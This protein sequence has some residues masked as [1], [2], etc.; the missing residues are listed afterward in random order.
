[1]KWDS[2]IKQYIGKKTK[3]GR[4]EYVLDNKQKFHPTVPHEL[5]ELSQELKNSM[6]L[7][8]P[9][10][11]DT[12]W[13][14]E[15]MVHQIFHHTLVVETDKDTLE[16]VFNKLKE[17]HEHVFLNPDGQVYEYYIAGTDNAIVVKSLIS[18]APIINENDLCIP[19]LEKLLVDILGDSKLYISQDAE[20]E[21]IYETSFHKYTINRS[22][23]K[24]Y[25]RRRN[26]LNLVESKLKQLN[27]EI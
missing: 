8:Q 13:F 19:S 25:A 14:N 22:T 9:C 11:I 18:E 27:L 26:R 16:A 21:V 23:L 6:P 7:V 15:F 20:S 10:F 17:R 5:L 4:G 1:M 24:R 2:H 12:R 3:I